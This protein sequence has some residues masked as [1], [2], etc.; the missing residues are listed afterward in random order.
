MT[1]VAAESPVTTGTSSR[2]QFGEGEV[3]SS[4]SS[5]IDP[6][7]PSIH[8]DLGPRTSDDALIVKPEFS[9][10]PQDITLDVEQ[11][12]VSADALLP[13]VDID[14]RSHWSRLMTR[15][16]NSEENSPRGTPQALTPTPS[17]TSKP[18]KAEPLPGTTPHT[19]GT[20]NRSM[21]MG[22]SIKEH[23]GVSLSQKTINQR[24]NVVARSSPASSPPCQLQ[25][26][27]VGMTETGVGSASLSSTS[28]PAASSVDVLAKRTKQL[29]LLDS[30]LAEESTKGTLPLPPKSAHIFGAYP[31]TSTGLFPD[32][33]R[34]PIR[35]ASVNMGA[36]RTLNTPYHHQPNVSIS[37]LAGV[38]PVPAPLHHQYTHPPQGHPPQL[39]L[40]GNGLSTLGRPPTSP[41]SQFPLTSYSATHLP[42]FDAH[43]I[44]AAHRG[45]MLSILSGEP[46]GLRFP[47]AGGGFRPG[48]AFHD[49][50]T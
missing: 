22:P 39:P 44:D 45:Q 15:L 17:I 49:T 5:S 29:Q 43:A 13:G 35:P 26:S 24:P 3:Y 36:P 32:Q 50:G 42:P 31:H 33:V 4:Q 25:P 10:H 28:P 47:N 8:G 20:I 2:S 16:N 21:R 46:S 27:G 19:T 9:T 14:P 23:P 41:S 34:M 38:L 7:T 37:T 11:E 40:R 1:R 30:V 18:T 6:H 12:G 48:S